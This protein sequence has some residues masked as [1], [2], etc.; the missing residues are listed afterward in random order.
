VFGTTRFGGFN[1][2]GTVF[3]LIPNAKKTAFSYVVLH[4][5]CSRGNPCPGVFRKRSDGANPAAGLSIGAN[6]NLFGTTLNAGQFLGGTIFEM[7]PLPN[8]LEFVAYSFCAFGGPA[9]TDGANPVAGV[10]EDPQGNFYTTTQQGGR[11]GGGTVFEHTLHGAVVLHDF[12]S[13]PNCTD[14]KLPVAGLVR[15]GAGNLYGTTMDGGGSFNAGAVFK[16]APGFP[17]PRE[18]VIHTFCTSPSC[19]DGAFPEAGLII[20]AGGDL[21]GTTDSG[22]ANDSGTV[23]ELIPNK[24]RTAY[25]D[26]VLYSF[27]QQTRCTD[28]ANSVAVLVRDHAGN[29]YGT[30]ALGGNP[31]ANGGNGFGTVFELVAHKS[32]TTTEYTEQVLY[33]FCSRAHCTDGALPEA[34]LVMGQDGNLYGTTKLGGLTGVGLAANGGGTVFKLTR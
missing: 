22:G 27:C 32:G 7:K 17:R 34:G 14:G 10:I 28:G 20:D 33:R 2:N 25:R 13:L 23:F 11:F 16:L 19:T 4:R 12:C 1:E 30:T 6:G 31:A 21:Y 5:F 29:L 26:R 8:G 15:D 3:E 24:A 18:T 9:C